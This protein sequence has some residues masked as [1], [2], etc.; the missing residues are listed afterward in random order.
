[1]WLIVGLGNPGADYLWT[2]HNLG[3]LV[4]DHLAARAG[5]RVER[6]EA[7]SFAG[8]GRIGGREVALAKPQTYMNLSGMAVRELAARFAAAPEETLVVVDDVALPWGTLRIRE[9][10]SAG[11]HNGLKS[12]VGALGT[13]LFPRVR[14]GIK[15]E[16]PV[17][18]LAS[19]VLSPIRKSE[20]EAAA[21][22]VEAAADAVEIILG[23]GLMQAMNRFNRKVE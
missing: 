8:L 23:D 18:D 4:V 21:A 13:D 10:G 6:P 2:P 17:A 7:Q 20:R 16:H 14:I 12:I 1:M 5:I 11:G 3:F 22:M 15:P 19:Y 9:H